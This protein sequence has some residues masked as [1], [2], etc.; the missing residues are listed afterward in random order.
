MHVM[1]MRS[2]GNDWQIASSGNRQITARMV[3]AALGWRAQAV[4]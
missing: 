3:R 4:Q 1:A 2:D